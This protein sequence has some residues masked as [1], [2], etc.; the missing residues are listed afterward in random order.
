V[1]HSRRALHKARVE[2]E[3]NKAGALSVKRSRRALHTARVE[4]EENKAGALSVKHSKDPP[5][6]QD[7]LSAPQRE[8]QALQARPASACMWVVKRAWG[9]AGGAD[10][11]CCLRADSLAHAMRVVCLQGFKLEFQ[12]EQN[13]YFKNALVRPAPGEHCPSPFQARLCGRFS[14]SVTLLLASATAPLCASDVCR[15]PSGPFSLT[16]P[17]H[18]LLSFLSA[19]QLVKSY[20]MIDEEEPI[21]EK[22]EG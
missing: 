19:L 4:R 21:L 8:K 17:S 13:P 18:L 2:Q 16:H 10:Q 5:R 3:E 20:H 14:F 12:F 15:L 6:S 9:L 7:T 11:E 22:A 1:K